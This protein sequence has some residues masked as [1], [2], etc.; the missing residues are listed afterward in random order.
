MRHVESKVLDMMSN[1]CQSL[2]PVGPCER[3]GREGEM[4]P[5]EHFPGNE[6]ATGRV[7]QAHGAQVGLAE[8]G[9]EA[10]PDIALRP[11]AVEG[12][13]FHCHCIVAPD[14][15][16]LILCSRIYL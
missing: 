8:V 13:V 15:M 5:L 10:V 16:L 9:D 6:I 1:A 3:I 11:E 2:D 4:Y 7:A 14:C 12:V